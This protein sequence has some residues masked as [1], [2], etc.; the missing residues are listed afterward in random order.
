MLLR[1]STSSV[2]ALLC[3]DAIVKAAFGEMGVMRFGS[4]IGEDQR[5]FNQEDKRNVDREMESRRDC[6]FTSWSGGWCLITGQ[7]GYELLALQD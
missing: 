2:S 1:I 3:F 5:S 6:E 4:C 7:R